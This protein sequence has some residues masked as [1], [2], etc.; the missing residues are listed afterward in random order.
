MY[1]A[2]CQVFCPLSCLVPHCKGSCAWI[3]LQ[4]HCILPPYV[5]LILCLLVKFAIRL[6]SHLCHFSVAFAK[7][8]D[9]CRSPYFKHLL[10][11]YGGKDSTAL[12]SK[13]AVLVVNDLHIFCGEHAVLAV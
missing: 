8:R 7:F 3:P 1:I 11:F 2:C 13:F 9:H 4:S 12:L 5:A 10:V 6:P